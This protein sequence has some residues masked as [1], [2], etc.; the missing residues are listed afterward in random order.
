MERN[1]PLFARLMRK[2][3]SQLLSLI[4]EN[5]QVGH[6]RLNRHTINIVKCVI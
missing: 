4:I 6:P 1:P 5:Y 3:D 2:G